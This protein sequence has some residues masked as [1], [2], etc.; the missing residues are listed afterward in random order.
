MS[1][2][3]NTASDRRNQ[4]SERK[5]FGGFGYEDTGRSQ[6]ISGSC[7]FYPFDNDRRMHI[8]GVDPA[9]QYGDYQNQDSPSCDCGEKSDG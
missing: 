3:K 4:C 1:T 8:G 7:G 9:D 6:R 5:V 2:A